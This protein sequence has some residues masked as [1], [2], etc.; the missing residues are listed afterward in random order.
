M[1]RTTEGI[2]S[3]KGPMEELV[4]YYAYLFPCEI[5]TNV[6]DIFGM[7]KLPTL[8][9]DFT[10]SF[11]KKLRLY[12]YEILPKTLLKIM[13]PIFHGNLVCFNIFGRG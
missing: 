11:P 12:K 4:F 6:H 5:K 8:I 9:P 3:S 13:L 10:S 1:A 2:G 7:R